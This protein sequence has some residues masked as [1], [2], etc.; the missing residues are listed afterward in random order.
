MQTLNDLL[1]VIHAVNKVA[2]QNHRQLG[3][4]RSLPFQ[5]VIFID[6]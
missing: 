2:Y 1:M 5:I 4:G 6:I 3:N